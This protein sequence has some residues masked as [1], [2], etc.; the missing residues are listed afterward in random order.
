MSGSS[1]K[2]ANSGAIADF[3]RE[4]SV[5][6]GISKERL[7][8]AIRASQALSKEELK[9]VASLVDFAQTGASPKKRS[10][11][12]RGIVSALKMIQEVDDDPFASVDEPM[13]TAEAM[14]ELAL[15]EVEAQANRE[16]I[17]KDSVSAAAAAE[18][19]GRSR[20]AIERLRRTNRLLALRVGNQWL[21]PR[22]Q[23]EPDAP[24]GVLPGLGEALQILDLSPAG[25]A[26]WFLHPYERLG[27][28]P[29][30]ELL[31]RRRPEP[32]LQ[33]A[34]EHSYMP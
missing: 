29:P 23:F 14:E 22:W 3:V 21:Y 32:V 10:A 2:L 20:Q 19:T 4:A 25:A 31:R 11:V 17:L 16:S 33:L 5:H 13:S 27:G 9:A 24:G 1:A 7:T 34:R 30:V 6:L 8:T 15:A 26:F 28:A 12:S 18:L